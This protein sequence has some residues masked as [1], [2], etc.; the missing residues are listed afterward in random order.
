MFSFESF[1]LFRIVT[2]VILSVLLATGCGS[3]SAIEKP[4]TYVGEVTSA[5]LED[6]YLVTKDDERLAFG[7]V[8]VGYEQ[9]TGLLTDALPFPKVDI[10]D[11][12]YGATQPVAAY[13]DS[14]ANNNGWLEGPELLVLYIRE[15]AI[16]LGHPVDYLAVNPPI[17]ALATSPAEIGGLLKFVK[18]NKARMT[19]EAQQIFRDIEQLGLDYR[20]RGKARTSRGG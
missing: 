4:P 7:D 17:N 19:D 12:V 3:P 5:R 10:A 8:F 13:Y 15:S 20:N 14:R 9:Q 16:G 11:I 6:I 1:S 2:A 18:T